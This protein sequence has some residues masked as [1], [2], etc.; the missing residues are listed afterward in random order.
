MTTI[1]AAP[2]KQIKKP[3]S[4]NLVQKSLYLMI[5]PAV[6]LIGIY[7]YGPLMGW[8]IAF[9]NFNLAKGLFGSKWIGLENFKFIF[10][11]PEFHQAL[12][13]SFFIASMKLVAGT[14]VQVGVSLMLNEMRWVGTKR[15]IQTTIYL[16]N[17]ISWVMIAGIV[18]DVLSPS[19][20][21]INLVIKALGGQPIMFL[22]DKTLFPYVLVATDIWK[23]FGF[24]TIIYLSTLTSIDPN[25]YEAA[26]IDG[27]GRFSRMWHITMPGLIPIIALLTTLNL[28]SILN[29]GFDQVIN[30]Y[31]PLVYKSGDILDTLVY[32]I[33]LG[34]GAS[35]VPQYD[36]ATAV[37]MFQS[38][39]SFALVSVTYYMAYR[40]ADYRIF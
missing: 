13:N 15:A 35:S 21:A 37:G 33:G 20:G 39:V 14:V 16:P 25:L 1:T 18:T 24:G 22:T 30:L 32:R 11:L 26:S 38:V 29:A 27:A 36:I 5:L 3:K 17:F 4:H 28:G 6:V 9:Q 34:S 8:S 2:F 31:S 40:Y 7:S 12:F 19:T 10:S 23:E